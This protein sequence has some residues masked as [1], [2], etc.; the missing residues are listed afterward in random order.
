LP[1]CVVSPM[2]IAALS[3]VYPL[4]VHTLLV[5]TLLVHALLVLSHH[6]ALDDHY[7]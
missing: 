4:L 5:Y 6:N 2:V 7:L 1:L 3:F